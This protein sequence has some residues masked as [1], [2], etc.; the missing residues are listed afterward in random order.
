MTFSGFLFAVA[1]FFLF[2]FKDYEFYASDP[3][4]PEYLPLPRWTYTLAAL[5][6]FLAYTLGKYNTNSVQ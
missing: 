3:D 2:S 4:R 5:F 1:T 6:L